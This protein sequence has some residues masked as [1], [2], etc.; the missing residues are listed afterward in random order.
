LK[1]TE[2]QKLYV[3]KVVPLKKVKKEDKALLKPLIKDKFFEGLSH[4]HLIP[5]H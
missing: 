3:L 1:N 2:T 4:K 5:V